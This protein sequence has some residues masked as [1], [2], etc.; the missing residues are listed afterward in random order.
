MALLKA[1]LVTCSLSSIIRPTEE[2]SDIPAIIVYIL[3]FISLY[4][5]VF[6]LITFLEYRPKLLVRRQNTPKHFPSVT[7][8]VPCYNEERTVKNTILSILDLNY[9]KDKLRVIAVNDG[10]ID[11][12]AKALAHFDIY[13]QV[14]ILHKEN[15]G[16]HTALNYA[17]R[18][19]TSDLVG[20]LDADS[21]VDRK[22]LIEIVKY[23][24]DKN[25]MAV[26]PAIKVFFK[27]YRKRSTN[28]VF[29]FGEHLRF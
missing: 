5:E 10:S 11:G 23:F 8:I 26:T 15:G 2:M 6:L 12:T 16:K 13:P 14:T 9:P 24:T 28:W 7:V 4:F 27:K 22:A 25:I 20:C 18:H 1:S 21:F 17:L 29:S 3:L 19:V